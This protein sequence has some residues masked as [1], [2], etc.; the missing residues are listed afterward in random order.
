MDATRLRTLH[1][2]GAVLSLGAI[3]GAVVAAAVGGPFA[4]LVFPLG[5]LGPLCGFYF[6]GGVLEDVPKYRVLGEELL[7]GVVWYGASLFGWSLLL[8]STSALSATPTTALGLP[9]VTALALSLLL[10]AVRKTTDRD[11]KV[12]SR[13]GQ[14]FVLVSALVVGGGLVLYAV[15]VQDASLLLV[16]LYGL[17]AVVGVLVWWRR[18]RRVHAVTGR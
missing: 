4:L 16:P 15:T 3:V 14:R 1:R 2:I 5:F 9:A 13:S 18:W 11:L 7:R 17:A 12:K 10:F 8:T 6:V